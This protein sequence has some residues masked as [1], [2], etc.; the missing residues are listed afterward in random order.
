[1]ENLLSKNSELKSKM[2][3][4]LD[5][6]KQVLQKIKNQERSDYVEEDEYEIMKDLDEQLRIVDADIQKEY[7]IV[8]KQIEEKKEIMI[9]FA[10]K[11]KELDR[12]NRLSDEIRDWERQKADFFDHFFRCS[13]QIEQNDL[14][15]RQNT[16]LYARAEQINHLKNQ[17]NELK[18]VM[19]ENEREKREVEPINR[20]E[21]NIMIDLQHENHRLKI[22]LRQLKAGQIPNAQKDKMN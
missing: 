8:K 19:T 12:F 5:V 11:E 6:T 13:K 2:L 21:H 17:I 16:T 1:M 10:K 4:L 14:Q 18:Q 3:S 20:K 22:E 7:A 9:M 15:I